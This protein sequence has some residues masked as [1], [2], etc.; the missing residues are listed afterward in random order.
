MRSFSMGLMLILSSSLFAQETTLK[1]DWIVDSEGDE[2]LVL[3][4][5]VLTKLKSITDGTRTSVYSGNINLEK[6]QLEILSAVNKIN[7]TAIYEVA[8]GDTLRKI[9]V[10]LYNN[11]NKWKEIYYLNKEI[12][13][14]EKLS[15]GMKLKVRP[16]DGNK[17]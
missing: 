3:E 4:N 13:A 12:L 10:K 2:V 5:K 7:T 8:A 17:E 9:A 1:D 16:A 14:V 6:A 11:E 15:V